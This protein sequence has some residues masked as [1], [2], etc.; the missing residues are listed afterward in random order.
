[1]VARCT[2]ERLMRQL[3]LAGRVRGRR[4]ATT[5]PAPVDDR[6]TDLVDRAFS[7][8][9]PNRQWVADITYV[10]TSSGFAYVA[11]VTAALSR[12]IVAFG[13]AALCGRT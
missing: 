10:A 9:V 11:L 7:R 1:M 8:A 3:G 4:R 13:S 12:V 2:V 6:P 5:V